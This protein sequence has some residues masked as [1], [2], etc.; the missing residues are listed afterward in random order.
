[1]TLYIIGL[2]LNNEKDIT[3]NG[4]EAIKKSDFVYLE[5]YTS[6]LGCPVKNLERL[7][8]K[9]IIPADRNLVENEAESTILKNAKTKNVSFLVIGDPFSATTHVDIMLRAKELNIK[10]KIINN[11]SILT[12]IGITGLQLY[13]FGQTTSVPFNSKGIK[14]PVEVLKKN[15]KIGLHTL[16]LLDLNPEKEEYLTI[17][18]A[19][20]YLIENNVS[21]NMLCVG[22][23]ALG[24][25]KPEIKSGKIKE[26]L[27][28]NFKKY[29]QCLII[30]GK[31]HFMEEEALETYSTSS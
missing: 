19:L 15:Q 18:E 9:K 5:D 2:G 17:S 24:S 29:P 16:F 28:I 3:L 14:T 11:A 22:C 20:K 30:P 21:K 8:K 1:M 7:Y 26:V 31:L 25:D 10:V 6:S 27:K 13:K 23:A 4:L 12:A